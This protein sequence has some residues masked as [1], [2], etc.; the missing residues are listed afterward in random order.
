[1]DTILAYLSALVLILLLIDAAIV[2]LFVVFARKAWE[3]RPDI[4]GAPSAAGAAAGASKRAEAVRTAWAEIEGSAARG[5]EGK[6][7]AVINADRLA[8]RLLK[9]A[10]YEGEGALDRMRALPRERVA[11][12]ADLMAA[13]R[14]RNRLV[15]EVGF[16]PD[17]RAL[18]TALAQYRAF[19]TEVGYL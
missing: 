1:M 17:D 11:S 2:A 4:M 14:F 6:R 18:D 15:H 13:H 8:D 10:G 7:L 5:A 19:L 9:D 16:Q 3:A 12:A